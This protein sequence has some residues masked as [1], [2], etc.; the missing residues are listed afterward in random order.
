MKIRPTTE[1]ETVCPGCGA[2]LRYSYEEL[3]FNG[4]MDQRIACPACRY[5]VLVVQGGRIA[6]AVVPKVHNKAWIDVELPTGE[7]IFFSQE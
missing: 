5:N 1:Y 4:L 6:E 7:Q 3:R 2:I